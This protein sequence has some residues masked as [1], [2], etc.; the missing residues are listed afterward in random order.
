MPSFYGNDHINTPLRDA[1]RHKLPIDKLIYM[2]Y[3]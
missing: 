1:L 3:F 2:T